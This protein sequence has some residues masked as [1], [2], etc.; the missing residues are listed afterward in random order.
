MSFMQAAPG[1]PSAVSEF[2]HGL[3][4]LIYAAIFFWGPPLVVAGGLL[5]LPLLTRLDELLSK[6]KAAHCFPAEMY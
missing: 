2:F 4:G 3:L 5:F 6:A 1:A